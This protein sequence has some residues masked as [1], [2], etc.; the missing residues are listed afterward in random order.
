ML[1]QASCP[2]VNAA[3][4][5]ARAFPAKT[6]LSI[7]RAVLDHAIEASRF[8]SF[9]SF[10]ACLFSLTLLDGFLLPFFLLFLP[11]AITVLLYYLR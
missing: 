11:S 3:D 6:A 7:K 10:F 9:L 8:F 2:S 4:C 5:L 1:P